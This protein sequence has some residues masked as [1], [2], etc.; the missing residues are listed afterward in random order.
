[1]LVNYQEDF[2]I[3][4][5]TNSLYRGTAEHDVAGTTL[6]WSFSDLSL[7]SLPHANGSIQLFQ[8]KQTGSPP[9]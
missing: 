8:E 4:S 6:I 1:M 7:S 5:G 2:K 9:V 3:Y